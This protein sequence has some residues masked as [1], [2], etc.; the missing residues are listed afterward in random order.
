MN[1]A[2]PAILMHY[3]SRPACARMAPRVYRACNSDDSV[4][5]RSCSDICTFV[6]TQRTD[7]VTAI[8]DES[9]ES[10]GNFARAREPRNRTIAASRSS[11]LRSFFFPYFVR[12]FLSLSVVRCVRRVRESS[13]RALP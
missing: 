2:R 11:P 12:P 13:S 4:A 3:Q 9:P 1:R 7:T 10:A 8:A 5:R 6:F